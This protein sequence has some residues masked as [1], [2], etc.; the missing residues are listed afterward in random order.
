MH[1]AQRRILIQLIS[2]QK[3]IMQKYSKK[4]YPGELLC[5]E[6]LPAPGTHRCP[7]LCHAAHP[8]EQGPQQHHHVNH[9]HHQHLNHHPPHHYLHNYPFYPSKI[10]SFTFV[11][12]F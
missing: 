3:Q 5:V 12:V 9:Q 11:S 2:W 4:S 7:L 8:L 10:F 6:L 1:S